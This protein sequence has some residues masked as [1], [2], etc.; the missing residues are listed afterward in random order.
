[1]GSHND[2]QKEAQKAEDKR[3]A[4]VEATQKQIESI[5]SSPGREADIQDLIKATQSYLGQD[6]DKQ[7][8]V[9]QRQAKF[10]LARNGQTMGSYDVDL[11]RDL[12]QQY[13]RG[14]LEVTRRAQGAGNAL[15]DA[16]Q[17][18]KLD[19]F[20]QAAAGMD[21]TTAARNAAESMKAAAGLTRADALQS[22]LGDL[23]STFGEIRKNSLDQQ[24]RNQAEKYQYGSNPYT[25]NQ[26]FSAGYGGGSGVGP[27]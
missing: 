16:D 5:Y 14:A 13:L 21:M 17:R 1:M 10:A 4:Q 27:R 26:Y 23:F 22:G 6:L 8:T 19:L 15:R 18:A 20:S 7:N 25:P 12:G 2:A 11:H 24:G 3:R 9:A